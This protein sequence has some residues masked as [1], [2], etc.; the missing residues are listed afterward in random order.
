QKLSQKLNLTELNIQA[1]YNRA[2]LSFLRGRYSDAIQ[3][4]NELREHYTNAGSFRHAALCDLDES[5]IYLQL[6]LSSDAFK[7]AKRAA[8]AFTQLGMK[9]EEAKA[10]AFVGMGLTHIQ[11]AGE[12]LQVFAESQ[13]IFEEE[14]N[15]Y[16]AASLELYRAQ[17]QFMLGRYWE[18]RCL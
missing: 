10:R 9:Y 2:Y 17:V 11:Q 1:K 3:G 13:R 8:D 12:A 6:N 15:L 7:L 4:F 16:W 5:E 14:N 18:S